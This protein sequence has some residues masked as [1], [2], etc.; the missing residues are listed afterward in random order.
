MSTKSKLSR[1]VGAS[2]LAALALG[3][4]FAIGSAPQQGTGSG[5]TTKSGGTTGQKV[6]DITKDAQK[7]LQQGADKVKDALGEG[8]PPLPPGWTPEDMQACIEAGT[9]GPMHAR[10]AK[11]AGNWKGTNKMWMAPG[12]EPMTTECVCVITSIMDGRYVQSDMSGEMPGMGA[13]KGL[14]FSGFDNVSKKFV[15]SWFDNHSTG[16]MTGTGELASDGSTIN[17]SF[18]YNCPVTK[19]QTVMREVESY[20]DANTMVL[21][22]FCTDPKSNK[23]YQCMKLELKRQGGTTTPAIRPTTTRPTT[24]P[25]TPPTR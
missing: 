10:L 25:S 4:A 23:E 22:M 17:W 9:P 5:S 14:G 13:F 2:A 11:N 20:P 6:D 19:K 7:K 16:I 15:G 18:A 3:T 24:P 12:T 8:M 21:D 1:L